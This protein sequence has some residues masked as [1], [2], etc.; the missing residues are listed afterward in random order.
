[1]FLLRYAQFYRDYA[2]ETPEAAKLAQVAGLTP[3]RSGQFR[4]YLT[5]VRRLFHI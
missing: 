1:M 4:Q 3:S 2:F 5:Y